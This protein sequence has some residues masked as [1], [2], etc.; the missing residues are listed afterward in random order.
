M[1]I[2]LIFPPGPHKVRSRDY[3]P[4]GIAKVAG[5]LRE[6]G[7]YVD[8]DDLQIKAMEHNR[9][10]IFRAQ[11]IDLNLLYDEQ[12]IFRCLG[13]GKDIPLDKFSDKSLSLTDCQGFDIIGFSILLKE[14]VLSALLLAKKIKESSKMPIIF[15]GLAAPQLGSQPYAAM[16]IA[17]ELLQDAPKENIF[18]TLGKDE[19]YRQI[20]DF[21]GLPLHLYGH[22]YFGNRLALPYKLDNGCV[23]KCSFCTYHILENFLV[24]NPEKIVNEIAAIKKKF[25]TNLF[26]FGTATINNNYKKLRELCDLIVDKKLQIKWISYASVSNMDDELLAKMKESGCHMLKY[27]IESGS[28]RILRRMGKPFTAERASRVLKM[29]KANQ[30]YNRINLIA[31]YPYETDED[32]GLTVKFIEEN[33][34][35]I[36]LVHHCR[37]YLLPESQMAIEPE[38]FGITNVRPDDGVSCSFDEINGL[39]WEYKKEQ[40]EKSLQTIRKAVYYKIIRSSVFYKMS[41]SAILPY[42]LYELVRSAAAKSHLLANV[43]SNFNGKVYR[44]AVC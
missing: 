1:K 6:K 42:S 28:D 16:P 38:K 33:K 30:I 12:R 26:D 18:Q 27:G 41:L 24:L 40:M 39:A 22:R 13:G 7:H 11:A 19:L 25:K 4:I 15:G 14:Q 44:G 36:D 20:P 21:K 43:W 34:G 9:R 29:T 17:Q 31:G 2:K 8:Q 3:P 23:Y 10:K 37:F 32:I 35:W 5:L